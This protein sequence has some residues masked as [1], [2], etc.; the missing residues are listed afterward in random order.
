M[1]GWMV[2]MTKTMKVMH[3]GHSDKVTER[4]THN[5]WNVARIEFEIHQ[6][7]IHT[8][9]WCCGSGLED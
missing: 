4:H 7:L 3:G 9:A 8:L 1:A 6:N 5:T 2:G